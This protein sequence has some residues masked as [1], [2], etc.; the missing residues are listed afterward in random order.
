MN[1]IHFYTTTVLN[2]VLYTQT[3][4]MINI[5]WIEL[6]ILSNIHVTLT[7]L[8]LI[9]KSGIFACRGVE[10]SSLW[11]VD[12]YNLLLIFPKS[13]ILKKAKRRKISINIITTSL[14]NHQNDIIYHIGFFQQGDQTQNLR[15]AFCLSRSNKISSLNSKCSQA[16]M[17]KF[18]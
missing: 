8:R 15:I 5:H 13:V 11:T 12:K 16:Y 17:Y 3:R 1:F 10:D 14:D 2:K 4:H 6:N 18:T 7:I 9:I